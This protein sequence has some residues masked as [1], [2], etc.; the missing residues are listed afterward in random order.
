MCVFGDRQSEDGDCVR[1]LASD[2]F[3]HGMT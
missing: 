3:M 1:S 2:P